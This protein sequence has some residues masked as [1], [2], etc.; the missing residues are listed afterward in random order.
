[1]RLLVLDLWNNRSARGIH[2]SLWIMLNS[3]DVCCNGQYIYKYQIVLPSC[4][5]SLQKKENKW[6]FCL[7]KIL[8]REFA[9]GR[10]FLV[11]MYY[12]PVW[13]ISIFLL[14]TLAPFL[15]YFPW[16]KIFYIHSCIESTSTIFTFL[17]S[18]F[19]SPPSNNS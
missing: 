1:M 3:T 5:P 4:S 18:F 12:S 13:F 6:H 17:I 11:Y 15:W 8:H 9:C 16:V 19:Y 10:H 14:S 7:F 2:W